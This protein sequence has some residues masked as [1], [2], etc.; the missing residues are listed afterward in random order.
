[1]NGDVTCFTDSGALYPENKT[2]EK[3][4]EWLQKHSNIGRKYF[5]IIMI[6]NVEMC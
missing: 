4:N 2:S 1:M 5:K 6:V 3:H